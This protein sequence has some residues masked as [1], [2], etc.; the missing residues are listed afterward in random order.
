MFKKIL[1]K[2]F[3]SRKRDFFTKKIIHLRFNQ[4]E[5]TYEPVNT[6]Y[7]NEMG[8]N[9][10]AYIFISEAD[11]WIKIFMDSE[12]EQL[13]SEIASNFE[14]KRLF[15]TDAF[16]H[17]TELLRI[18]QIGQLENHPAY[19]VEYQGRNDDRVMIKDNSFFH[20]SEWNADLNLHQK[21]R[22]FKN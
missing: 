19:I 3:G 9:K 14:N 2:L 17:P 12:F 5:N 6:S 15:E 22:Q 1:G 13:Q 4:Y 21:V 16:L 7:Q 10:F 11:R 18:L 8:E 20:F